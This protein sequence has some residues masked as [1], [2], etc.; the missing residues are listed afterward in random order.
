MGGISSGFTPTIF[1]MVDQAGNPRVEGWIQWEFQQ[2]YSSGGISLSVSGAVPTLSG[3]KD[4]GNYFRF[5]YDILVNP[6]RQVA[7]VAAPY[8]PMVNPET[9]NHAV[10]S[11]YPLIQ[12]FAPTGSGVW[13]P[14]ELADSTAVSGLRV[15]MLVIGY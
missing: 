2:N 10:A 1:T 4:F 7:S 8:T 14:S 9:L 5:V 3:Q 15:K 6:V 12:L 13:T 11:G